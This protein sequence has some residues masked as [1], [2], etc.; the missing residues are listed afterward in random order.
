[1]MWFV[2]GFFF[3]EGR[4]EVYK[5]GIWGIICGRWWG[6]VDVVVVC[7]FLGLFEYI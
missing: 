7:R 1:M 6:S 2:G 3:Y 5:N 4:V